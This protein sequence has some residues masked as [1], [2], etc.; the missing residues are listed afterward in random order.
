[1]LNLRTA[2]VSAVLLFAASELWGTLTARLTRTGSTRS[3]SASTAARS[4]GGRAGAA[5]PGA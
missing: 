5:R 4:V 2:L 3:A 1:M